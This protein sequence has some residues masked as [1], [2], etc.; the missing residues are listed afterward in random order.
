MA[1]YFSLRRENKRLVEENVLYRN[2]LK[3]DWTIRDFEEFTIQDSA[4]K[5]LYT[6]IEASVINNS[7]NKNHNYIIL[8]KGRENGIEPDMAVISEKGVVGIVKSVSEN[9]STVLSV[10]NLN[11]R[12]SGKF[13]N[14]KYFG[15]VTWN[16]RDPGVVLLN[17]ILHH[18][19]VNRG[20]TI[21][22]SGY[23]YIFPE[24]IAIGK[25]KNYSLK[26][27]FY[28]IE[29]DLFTNFRNLSQVYVVKNLQ[30]Q[31]LL[32]LEE[33]LQND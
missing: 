9:F 3:R 18:V 19:P 12:V 1:D 21:V 6:Y 14:Q 31:E 7:V 4:Y 13:K 16:G 30:K 10:L 2:Q 29:I 20:D 15:P 17:E 32:E 27:N 25:V 8:D 5:Q 33:Q 26:G 11:F 23:S 24:G 28:R 22:T